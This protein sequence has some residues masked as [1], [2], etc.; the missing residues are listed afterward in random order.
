MSQRASVKLLAEAEQACLE[1]GSCTARCSQQ[2]AEG[3]TI[4]AIAGKV[5]AAA[6]D[7]AVKHAVLS[8]S[9]CGYCCSEC[10]AGIDAARVM[11]AARE[12]LD[13][14][15]EGMSISRDD[16]FLGDELAVL[17]QYKAR[18]NIGYYD[19][20]NAH[21]DAVFYAGCS[22]AAFAPGLVRKVHAWLEERV[23]HVSLLDSCCGA[24]LAL[25]GLVEEAAAVR[26]RLR[27]RLLG[28]GATQLI[29]ACPSCLNELAGGLDGVRVVSL[30]TLLSRFGEKVR[31]HGRVTIHD[32][33]PDRA[34]LIA[35]HDVRAILADCEIVEMEHSGRNTVCCG[36]GGLVSRAHPS[37][38]DARARAR[39]QE[40]RATQSDH[41]ITACGHCSHRLDGVA[42]PGEVLHYL[43]LVFDHRIDWTDVSLKLDALLR[44]ASPA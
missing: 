20:Q 42:R 12:V 29:V 34:S 36:S 5:L 39:I 16:L 24:P 19:L 31:C 35:G 18:H 17:A 33:C 3:L 8:C 38:A 37:L 22:L 1:C 27:G 4:G 14:M 25:A 23:S 15:G 32:S 9:V 7:N 11:V 30:T 40:F 10:P 44:E 6:T 2:R 26:T 28:S 41:L 43:E 13:A 21:C